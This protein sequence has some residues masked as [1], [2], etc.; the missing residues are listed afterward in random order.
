MGK[1]LMI[2]GVICFIAGLVMTFGP[3]LP[4]LGKLPGDIAVDK[5]NVKFYFPLTTSIL[6]SIVL[7][8]LLFLYQRF[9]NH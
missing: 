5:G 3:K 7:S 6:V 8:V 1:L 2:V 9:K 4:W